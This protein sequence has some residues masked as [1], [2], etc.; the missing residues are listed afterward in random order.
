MNIFLNVLLDQL[1][2]L[3]F[4]VSEY[5]KVSDHLVFVPYFQK[6]Q[7]CL[8]YLRPKSHGQIVHSVHCVITFF[9]YTI[10]AKNITPVFYQRI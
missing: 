4:F 2:D 7:C 9:D 6:S 3:I 10:I 8:K 5:P 1:L